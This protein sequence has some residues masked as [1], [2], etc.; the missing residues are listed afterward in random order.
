MTRWLGD[1]VRW[2]RSG[3][4][5]PTSKAPARAPGAL[6]LTVASATV[7]EARVASQQAF[8]LGAKGGVIRAGP[9]EE[10]RTLIER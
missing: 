2:S 1:K 10:R 5:P 7:G 3:A 6:Q 8:H 4:S 9:R